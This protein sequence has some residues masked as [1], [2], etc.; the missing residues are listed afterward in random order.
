MKI[1]LNIQWKLTLWTGALLA[2]V[3]GGIS[4]LA[5][6]RQ[7][8]ALIEEIQKR[9]FS[10]AETLA[11]SVAEGIIT[12]DVDSV[13]HTVDSLMREDYVVYAVVLDKEGRVMM[14]AD[15]EEVGKVYKDPLTLD[16]IRAESPYVKEYALSPKQSVFDITAPIRSGA[17]RL[18]TIRL[19]YSKKAI[20]GSVSKIKKQI[21]GIAFAAVFVSFFGAVLLARA[22]V[23]PVKT[24]TEAVRLVLL[25]GTLRRRVNISTKDEIGELA[26]AFNKMTDS[27]RLSADKLISARDYAANV[28]N[29]MADSIIVANP[30]GTIKMVNAAAEDL[31][32]CKEGELAGKPAKIIFAEENELF[33]GV[34]FEQLLKEGSFRDYDSAYRT[35]DGGKIPVSFSASVLRDRDGGLE[36]IVCIGHDMRE[37]LRLQERLAQ[38][39]KLSAV[40]QLAAGVAHEINNPIGVILGFAQGAVSRLKED[41]PYALPLRSIEREATRCKNLVRNLLLF[42]RQTAPRTELLDVDAVIGEALLLV[43]TQSKF[44]SVE[45]VQELGSGGRIQGDKTQVQ[46]VVLTLCNNAIDAMPEGGRLTVRT[47]REEKPGEPRIVLEVQD[48]GTGIKDSARNRLFEPFFTTKEPGKGTGLGLALAHEII[49]KHCGT[50]EVV[51]TAGKGATFTVSLPVV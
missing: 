6:S 20:E 5:I 47:R 4:A 45:L 42:S 11:G 14:H 8:T 35:K 34:W 32:G 13:K 29:S 26:D 44:K 10:M 15:L 3:I 43:R 33:K 41:D 37:I 36:G 46:Q 9:G 28:V 50:I 39:E 21:L 2:L 1:R 24:L 12:D 25:E 18:G 17:E 40:G 22:I 49:T 23:A 48:T 27:L 30:D 31:L 51:S 38:S 7:K 16:S 19:G